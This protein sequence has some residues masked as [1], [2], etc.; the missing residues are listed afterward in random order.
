MMKKL[1][2]ILFATVVVGVVSQTPSQARDMKKNYVGGGATFVGNTTGFGITSKIGVADNISV[3]PFVSILGSS[4]NVTAYL[5]GVSATYDFNIP[6][7]DFSPY[8]GVGYGVLGITNGIDTVSDGSVYAE[9]GADY[10]VANSVV[11]NGNYRLIRGDGAFSIG[12]GY[13]F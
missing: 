13:R 8:A 12:A 7:S 3:R 11:V 4:N 10:N 5:G 6:N 2:S 9:A 1:L